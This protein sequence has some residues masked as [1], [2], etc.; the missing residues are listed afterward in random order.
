M[1]PTARTLTHLRRL[2]FLA[3]VVRDWESAALAGSGPD[4]RVVL[5]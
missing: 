3:D 1:T 2:G 4:T 5:N